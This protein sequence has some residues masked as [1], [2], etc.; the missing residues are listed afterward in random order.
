MAEKAATFTLNDKNWQT[1]ISRAS[2]NSSYVK[3]ML[4]AWVKIYS[5]DME[6]RFVKNT[7]GGGSW[8]PIKKTTASR[9]GNSNILQDTGKLRK[10]LQLG[11]QGNLV[12]FL[13]KELAVFYGYSKSKHSKNLSFQKLASIHQNGEGHNPK[14]EIFVKP[15]REALQAMIRATQYALQRMQ[16]DLR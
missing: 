16:G 11:A 2:T 13:A 10:G 4:T 5:A 1:F 8:P 15:S 3:W 7:R 14:R 6:R 12:R 9:K